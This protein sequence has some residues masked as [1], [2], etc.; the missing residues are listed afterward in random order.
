VN[1]TCE[2]PVAVTYEPL[3]T[4]AVANFN[5]GAWLVA[6]SVVFASRLGRL[7]SQDARLDVRRLQ[8]D[9]ERGRALSAD[10]RKRR[11]IW[12]LEEAARLAGEDA[13][14]VEEVAIRAKQ[15][16]QR[17]VELQ[18]KMREEA[19]EAAAR[20][21]A[22]RDSKRKAY[23]AQQ[24]LLDAEYKSRLEKEKQL[25]EEQR[26]KQRLAE[27]ARRKAAEEKRQREIEE[28]RRKAEEER[29]AEEQTIRL[30]AEERKRL[31]KE[32]RK[33]AI[34]VEG[35]VAVQRPPRGTLLPGP[36]EKEAA[37]R[38]STTTG[39]L[40]GGQGSPINMDYASLDDARMAAPGAVGPSVRSACDAAASAMRLQ[41]ITGSGPMSAMEQP[42]QDHWMAMATARSVVAALRCAENA[43]SKF[44]DA[45]SA[46]EQKD[47]FQVRTEIGVLPES[48]PQRPEVVLGRA[49]R[50]VE[51]GEATK[52]VSDILQN[53]MEVEN[54]SFYTNL[55][56]SEL[57]KSLQ[58]APKTLGSAF[59]LAHF[60]NRMLYDRPARSSDAPAWFEGAAALVRK[61]LAELVGG[62][63]P[64]SLEA[65]AAVLS[66]AL[67][68]DNPVAIEAAVL[69]ATNIS[70]AE[71]TRRAERER[72]RQSE[73]AAK[74]LEEEWPDAEEI[75]AARMADKEAKTP[76]AERVWALRNV[77]G[78]LAL[79]GPGERARAR[80]LLEQAVQVKQQYAGA[81]DHPCIFPEALALAQVMESESDWEQDA[82]GV[83]TLTLRVLSNI[84]SRYAQSNDNASA[85]LLMES[86]LRILEESAGVRS[87]SVRAATR[88]ADQYLELLTPDERSKVAAKRGEAQHVLNKVSEG[89]T[90]KLG[91]YQEGIV[92]NIVNEWDDRG[93]AII[94]PLL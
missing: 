42:E 81:P 50:L 12:R 10:L 74:L 53:T 16:A 36:L 93:A 29:K 65:Y 39:S 17:Q 60:L 46:G 43:L 69:A 61:Q 55:S 92:K 85:A 72:A 32:K 76:I 14:R 31:E 9:R 80:Q 64:D 47:D 84:A 2:P 59:E 68:N 89:L 35:S 45:P 67:G 57:P 49:I 11:E 28:R 38:L 30:R 75:R 83:S 44:G 1:K 86:G 41:A 4:P 34:R 3:A 22:E 82:A 58:N 88:R 63:A 51:A 15:E 13:K 5:S 91:A 62:A 6:L 73:L 20:I 71:K 40:L 19:T 54:E 37:V 26:E 94:G 77:A 70:P 56:G 23:E 52:A 87:Q 7:T 78:T 66:T 90:E 24:A 33:F 21:T 18:R 8:R 27:E 48:H 25:L 79:G